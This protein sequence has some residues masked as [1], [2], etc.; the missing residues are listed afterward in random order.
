MPAIA[1]AAQLPFTE[2]L[3]PGASP[4]PVSQWAEVA[5]AAVRLPLATALASVLALRPRRRGTPER[6]LAV[7]HT[8]IILAVVGALVMLV[9]G[10]S[11][12]RAFGIV[13]AAG[14]RALPRE[15]RRSEG[16]GRHAV[17]AGDRPGH[18]RRTLD[19]RHLRHGVPAGAPVGGRV[20]RASR[21]PEHDRHAQDRRRPG[22]EGQ[23]GTGAAASGR[24]VRRAGDVARRTGVRR[25]VA[26][27]P[28]VGPAVR[29][30]CRD[31]T[32]RGNS[33]SR[34]TSRRS[35]RVIIM[36]LVTQP[37]DGVEP[38]LSAIEKAKKSIDIVVF[39]LDIKEVVSGLHM[40]VKRGVAVRA[41]IAHTNKGGEKALRKLE[42]RLLDAGVTVSRTADELVRYHGKMMIVDGRR[43]YVN[44]FNF[45]WIDVE[46][47]RSFGAVTAAPRLVK[48]GLKLFQA[49]LDRQ[50]YVSSCD[51]LVVSPDNARVRLSAFIKGARKQLLVYDP[52]AS[53]PR[54]L[55]LLAERARAGLD[56]RII[57]ALGAR[58]IVTAQ[59]Y[60]GKRLHVRAIIRDGR[61][62][63]LGSQSLRALELDRRRELGVIIREAPA[64][65]KMAAVFEADWALTPGARKIQEEEKPGPPS[66]R[67]PSGASA[68]ASA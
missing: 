35:E 16:R 61:Q 43:V 10:S 12:A 68:G 32:R 64:V 28:A 2:P 62:A 13:G 58:A 49:D 53:D 30:G 23:G 7:I 4:D 48:E 9:V 65:K 60:P 55:R 6:N 51:R 24:V 36:Q 29:S 8:Q 63:F 37:D 18:R 14:L 5:S 52:N 34:S 45:T 17:D 44:G 27:R 25:P 50:P 42:T 56:V 31:W 41:L 47:S 67:A 46:R 1:A 19:D 59:K 40:A 15:D 26:R 66:A 39:R 21:G 3:A 57:G 54:M 20:L 11:L 33:K 38:V 22:G